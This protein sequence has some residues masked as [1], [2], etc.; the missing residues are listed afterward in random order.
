MPSPLS[1]VRKVDTVTGAT[2]DALTPKLDHI[3][4]DR[5]D[6]VRDDAEAIRLLSERVPVPA[7]VNNHFAGYS[8]AT[9][10]QLGQALG[11]PR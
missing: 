1:V 7:F 10:E 6:Q 11:L 2:G 3:V 8:P 5:A 4:V 9:I